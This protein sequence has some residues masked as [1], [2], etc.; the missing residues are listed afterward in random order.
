MSAQ[1]SA[2]RRRVV[3]AYDEAAARYDRVT[4]SNYV[5]QWMR[6]TSLELL[7]ETFKP[8]QLILELG[9]GT[10]SEA[11]ELARRGITIMATDISP[12]MI[13]LL[14]SK[15]RKEGLRGIIETRVLAI[16]QID[17]LIEEFGEAS[18]DGAY[19]SFAISYELEINNVPA[20]LWKLLK[21]PS[22]IALS[23]GNRLSAWT[24]IWS[25]VT[26]NARQV[27]KRV[28]RVFDLEVGNH[29]LPL[30]FYTLGEIGQLFLPYFKI[31]RVLALPLLL[32]PPQL[33]GIYE[34]FV[35][36]KELIESVERRVR[37]YPILR[38]WGDHILLRMIRLREAPS[39]N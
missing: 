26:L 38:G 6:R 3:V 18:F 13:G 24:L 39:C 2:H 28:R 34:R 25:L 31:D 20:T 21:E 37:H 23:A 35:G 36:A 12:T 1:H 15:I 9:C 19:S 33:S 5:N 4:E 30:R 11:L 16:S 22:Y 29:I 27:M 17:R 14:D 32:P 10:G 8:G 7:L